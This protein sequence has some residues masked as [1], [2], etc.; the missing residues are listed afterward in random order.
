[1]F[2]PPVVLLCSPGTAIEILKN[3]QVQKQNK[4]SGDEHDEYESMTDYIVFYDEPTATGM[5]QPSEN[6]TVIAEFARFIKVMPKWTIL[7]CATLKNVTHYP[8]LCSFFRSKYP[9]AKLETVNNSKIPIGASIMDFE[10]KVQMPHGKCTTPQQLQAVITKLEDEII[11]KKFYTHRIVFSM[12][13]HLKTLVATIPAHLEFGTYISSHE[14]TQD[15]IQDLA[16]EYLNFV[17]ASSAT[18]PALVERFCSQEIVLSGFNTSNILSNATQLRSQTLIVASDP[19]RQ[20]KESVRS[21]YQRILA[22][23]QATSFAGVLSAH[24]ASIAEWQELR[25]EAEKRE[26]NKKSSGG[27]KKGRD[28]EE[29]GKKTKSTFDINTEGSLDMRM[30]RWVSENP[31]PSLNIPSRFCIRSL[32]QT[33]EKVR[34][35]IDYSS[36]GY[37]DIEPNS[38][39]VEAD[40]MLKVMLAAGVGVY[41]TQLDESYLKLMTQ[42]M[43]KGN[44]SFVFVNDEICYGVNYPIENIVI[45]DTPLMVERS[46]NTL[47][48]LV[49][50]AGRKG[51][52]DKANIWMSTPVISKLMDY[53]SNHE[54][55]DVEFNNIRLACIMA[56]AH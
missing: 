35:M 3:N 23:Y 6:N 7:S 17:L 49:S 24:R 21:H 31:C 56:M 13:A 41:T 38:G 55:V 9:D 22:H 19:V 37:N 45:L 43:E 30:E 51:K 10:G 44:L 1:M 34:G 46:V 4:A 5:D 14:I 54:F 33:K 50:R 8:E 47:L 20:F 29:G 18:N 48:Q 27:K 32:S 15:S 36:D 39:D 42:Q 11:L 52:S 12:H 2:T 16:M 40:D 25:A 26:A 28:S 53:I